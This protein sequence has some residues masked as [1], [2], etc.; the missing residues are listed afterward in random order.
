MRLCIK[1]AVILFLL[2]LSTAAFAG[3]PEFRAAW[4]TAWVDGFL[5]PEQADKTIQA[6][7]DANLNAL[8]IQV[9]KT[10]DA[11]YVSGLEPRAT[12]ISD[13]SDY[14]PLAYVIEKAHA[15]GIEVHAWFV[16]FRAWTGKGLPGSPQH[17]YN[18]HPEWFSRTY[19]SEMVS[20]EGMWLDPGVPEVRDYTVKLVSDLVRRY[21]VDGVQLDY[22]RYAGRDW[23]YSP[24][25]LVAFQADTGRKDKPKPTDPEWCAWRRDRVTSTVRSIYREVSAMKPEVKVTASTIPWGDCP[26]TF[27]KSTPYSVVFQDWRRWMEEGIIDANVIMNYKDET[28]A[29][30]QLAFRNWINGAN[31][32]RYDR[33][34]YIGQTFSGN[35]KSV[36]TQIEACRKRGSNG[37]A[38]FYFNDTPWRPKLVEALRT[39]AFGQQAKAPEMPWKRE[40]ILA[41][42]KSSLEQAEKMLCEN[43]DHE[44]ALPLLTRVVKLEP[45]NIKAHLL[46]GSCYLKKGMRDDAAAKFEQ[47]LKID[48]SNETAKEGLKNSQ[49]QVAEVT[50]AEPAKPTP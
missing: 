17:V 49:E 1:T 43:S 20:G 34:A 7:K 42:C 27:S 30:G 15:S 46:I 8:F 41:S 24:A 28:K 44:S 35:T 25:A 48:P 32:W 12:N 31:K 5:S 38:G 22:I 47:V 18:L 16:V 3:E 36:L 21:D 14:D 19:S 37:I 10:G 2:I 6:A 26:S 13:N 39:Y 40:A 45:E 29:S 4:I 11:Y 9:R 33:H 23:G 50:P